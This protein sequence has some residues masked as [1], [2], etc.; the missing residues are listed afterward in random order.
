M[1]HK[2]SL[3]VYPGWYILSEDGGMLPTN[4]EKKGG[5]CV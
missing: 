3:Q 1:G 4:F 5:P 2:K